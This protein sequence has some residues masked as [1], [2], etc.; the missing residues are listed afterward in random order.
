MTLIGTRNF[1]RSEA[2]KASGGFIPSE[3]EDNAQKTLE[4]LQAF[5]DI[6][7]KPIL[8][9]SLYR[10]PLHNAEVEGSAD[11]SQHMKADAADFNVIGMTNHEAATKLLAAKLPAYHQLI[12]YDKTNH[13]HVGRGSTRQNLV[14]TATGYVTMTVEYMKKAKPA[15]SAVAIALVAV[16]IFFFLTTLSRRKR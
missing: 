11:H 8:V 10:S 4:L 9:T 5:R 3:L 6:L 7:G 12:S 14:K 2:L 16:G 1:T 13:L 15:I